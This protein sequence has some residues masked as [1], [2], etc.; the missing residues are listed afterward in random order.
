MGGVVSGIVGGIGGLIGGKQKS[1]AIKDSS[2][3]AAQTARLGFDY[4]TESPLATE[5]LPAGGRASSA[6]EGLL[7][8]G[9]DPAAARAAFENYLGST[10]FDFRL[11]RSLDA[12]T[13]NRAAG[14]SLNSGATLR[15]LQE[16][17]QQLASQEFANYLGQLGGVAQRGLAA[18]GAIGGAGSSAG[19]TGASAI[20][21]GGRA[22]ADANYQGFSDLIGGA[23]QVGQGL[24]NFF[25]PDD[26]E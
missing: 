3:L 15:A 9:G 11:N 12:I 19:A 23:T 8:V 18:G 16:R 17:G 14:G 21:S 10:G 2:Q 4:L 5:F 20:A 7:G 6:I 26:E 24:F 25:N 1:D 22:A 13:G